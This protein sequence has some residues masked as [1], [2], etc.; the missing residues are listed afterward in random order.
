MDEKR[1]KAMIHEEICTYEVSKLAKETG[2]QIE[3]DLFYNRNGELC[4]ERN[5]DSFDNKIQCY[6]P[7]QSQ[8][9]GWLRKNHQVDVWASTA[10]T[11]ATKNKRCYYWHIAYDTNNGMTISI[12]ESMVSYSTY[13][14]ALEEG[15]K[16]ALIEF[17]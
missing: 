17:V 16:D 5:Y 1:H 6:A 13:E 14:K 15:L 12:H 7:T 11:M 3:C 4:D 9:Q 2:F 8:L 10:A